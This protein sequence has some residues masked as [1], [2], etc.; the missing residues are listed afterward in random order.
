M[1]RGAVVKEDQGV[2]HLPRVALAVEVRF[3]S[4]QRVRVAAEGSLESLLQRTPPPSARS[5]WSGTCGARSERGGE[6]GTEGQGL[7]EA[8]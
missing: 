7:T 2:G 4:A 3:V 8:K 1:R 6:R 5:V